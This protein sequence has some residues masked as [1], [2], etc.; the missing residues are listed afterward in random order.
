[1]KK[2][3]EIRTEKLISYIIYDRSTGWSTTDKLFK[4]KMNY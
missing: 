1:M 4:A 2:L 3:N